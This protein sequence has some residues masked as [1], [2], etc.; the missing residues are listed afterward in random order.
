MKNKIRILAVTGTKSEYNIIF[1]LLKALEEHN[2]YTL[3]VIVS[4]AHLS[5]PHGFTVE[6]IEK[7]GLVRSPSDHLCVLANFEFK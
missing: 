2:D 7:D 5:E 3:E 6:M 1:P 4:G